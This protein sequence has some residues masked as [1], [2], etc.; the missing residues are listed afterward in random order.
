MSGIFAC[1][2]AVKRERSGNEMVNLGA[3]TLS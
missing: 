3:V 1:A 2:P